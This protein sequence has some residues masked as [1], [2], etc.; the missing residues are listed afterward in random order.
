MWRRESSE[1]I[2]E[3][4]LTPHPEGGYYREVLPEERK[5]FPWG[6]KEASPKVSLSYFLITAGEYFPFHHLRGDQ[7]WYLYW[8]GPLEFHLISQH[9]DYSMVPLAQDL[10]AGYTPKLKVEANTW[11]AVRTSRRVPWALAVC[12]F[13]A[14][15]DFAN[16]RV[17]S[18][19]ELL[20][21]YPHCKP[22]IYK[23]SRRKA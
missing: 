2:D 13:P 22:I 11:Q 1:I 19:Q 14:G 12:M 17:T 9:G 10:G 23:L 21:C 7:T 16:I 20:L 8:G 6:I 18:R 15:H 4:G 5:L 3:L